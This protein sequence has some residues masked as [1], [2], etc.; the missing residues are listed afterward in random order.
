MAPSTLTSMGYHNNFLFL[1]QPRLL[2]HLRGWLTSSCKLVHAGCLQLPNAWSCNCFQQPQHT[3]DKKNLHNCQKFKV[4]LVTNVMG[5]RSSSCCRFTSWKPR[6][7]WPI[8]STPPNLLPLRDDGH[9]NPHPPPG[10]YSPTIYFRN[11]E[12]AL[13]WGAAFATHHV[14]TMCQLLSLNQ[15]HNSI[16]QST[17]GWN[18]NTGYHHRMRFNI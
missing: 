18:S 10:D 1:Q 13:G 7:N 2:C 12:F 6:Q 8:H 5:T 3:M 9:M 14:M 4:R 16:N 15:S 11:D 17:N